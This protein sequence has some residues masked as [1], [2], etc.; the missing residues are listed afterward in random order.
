MTE[1]GICDICG[2]LLCAVVLCWFVLFISHYLTPLR[3]P[4][5][6]V[7]V[8]SRLGELEASHKEL[9]DHKYRSQA[10][11]RELKAKLK[12][13][14]EVSYMYCTCIDRVQCMHTCTY[15]VHVCVCTYNYCTLM[16]RNTH[17]LLKF[18]TSSTLH[19][20]YCRSVRGCRMSSRMCVVTTALWTQ[21]CTRERRRWPSSPPEWLCWSRR[22]RT[23]SRLI[24]NT[25]SRDPL[26][27][28]EHR[29]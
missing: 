25:S 13:T 12:S 20:I 8:E 4:L 16:K 1:F 6:L 15:T 24:Y 23:R 27:L 21:V 17:A 22:S 2:L 10:A 19:L 7:G 18:F 28:I 26:S 11:I 29:I 5:Q 14:E 3:P 9:T